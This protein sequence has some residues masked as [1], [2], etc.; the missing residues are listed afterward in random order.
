MPIPLV[1]LKAQ[2]QSI[3]P[4]IDAAMQRVVDNTSF[5]LGKEVAEFE[6]NFAAFSRVQHCVGTD[7]GTA[8]LHLALMLCGVQAGDEVITTTHTFVATAEVISLIGARPVFV[9][10]DPR[11]YNLAPDALERAI[12]PRTRAILPVHLYG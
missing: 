6:K 4:E 8:A 1:D 10:I 11:T 7:S 3:K 9:D 5:I 2:Y 12:T